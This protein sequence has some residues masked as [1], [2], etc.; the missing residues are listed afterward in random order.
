MQ[1]DRPFQWDL[2]DRLPAGEHVDTSQLPFLP[3]YLPKYEKKAKIYIEKGILRYFHTIRFNSDLEKY[4]IR[5]KMANKEPQ[6]K[7]K[8]EKVVLK[9]FY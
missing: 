4:D 3:K 7:K 2:R 9:I 8:D 6:G 1:V 5:E